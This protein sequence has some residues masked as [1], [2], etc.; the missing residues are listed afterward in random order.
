MNS[1][2]KKTL[3]K[4]LIFLVVFF[5][6][7]AIV[8][9]V[10]VYEFLYVVRTI[11]K[12]EY[13]DENYTLYLQTVGSQGFAGV[14]DGQLVLKEKNKEIAKYKFELKNHNKLLDETYFRVQW[15]EDKVTVILSW[16]K[17][18]DTMIQLSFDGTVRSQE[19]NTCFL[20]E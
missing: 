17:Q 2:V 5:M 14:I 1:S 19:L 12:Y 20:K 3:K 8:Y 4:V 15:N 9:G 11:E 13:I 7:C 10:I 16:Y 6:I 18:N